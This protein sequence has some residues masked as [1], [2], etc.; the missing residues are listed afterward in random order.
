MA[1]ALLD[2]IA[3]LTA[4][5]LVLVL[6]GAALLAA[7]GAWQ[8]ITPLLRAS[9]AVTA[10][11]LVAAVVLMLTMALH[12]S[13]AHLIWGLGAITIA[14][15][16]V[17]TIRFVRADAPSPERSSRAER[18]RAAAPFVPPSLVLVALGIF[19]A[20]QVRSDTFW[21]VALARRIAELDQLSSAALSFEAGARGNANYPLPVYHA[22]L[23][24]ADAAPRVDLWSATWFVTLWLGP[25]A[26]LAFAGMAGELLGD[27]RAQL[28][29][30][31]TFVAV[32]VLGYGPWY[33]AT[34]YLSYAG[35]VGIL[36]VLPLVV[37]ACTR[38][39]SARGRARA[40]Q[41]AIAAVGTACIGVLHGNYVLYPAL[42][43]GGMAALLLLGRRDAW[44]A[45]LAATGIVVV[46]G[47]VVLGA[48]LPWITNDDNFL[49][50]T[51]DPAGEP[52]A[53]TRHRDVFVGTEQ[54]H[55]VELGSL[56]TQ[57][58]L[59]L[60]ALALPLLLLARRRRAGPW[61]LAGGA[62][63]IVVF[64][65]TPLAIELLDGLGS[66]TPATRFDRVYPAALGVAA[67]AL[68]GGWLL[69][70]SAWER[71]ARTG[72]AASAGAF[73]VVAALAWWLDSI[74]DTRRIVVTAFVEARWV[75]GLDPS[76]IPRIAVVAAT[77]LVLAVAIWIR[78]R[79]RERGVQPARDGAGDQSE[80]RTHRIAAALV[81]AV[82]VGLAPASA[83]RAAKTWQPEAYVRAQR[84]DA[85]YS[86][87]EVYPPAARRAASQLPAGAVVLAGFN[88]AR[89][90]ASLAPVQSVEESILRELVDDPPTRSSAP[91]VLNEL[92]AEW[93]PDYVAA[94][95]Y[96]RSF[97]PLLDAAAA[98]PCRFELVA[99][100]Y[101]RIYRVTGDACS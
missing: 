90:I 91:G 33:F 62:V 50:G 42:F 59:V 93:H 12:G 10:T 77:L 28:V 35:Q 52:T 66:V 88:D 3:T 56:A 84:S 76:G 86:R 37:V 81:I 45:A 48:Q 4:T 2:L 68:A 26:M 43:A 72:R 74:R 22:L 24:V 83:A 53:F 85:T 29:G 13:R 51:S 15:G 18:L 32:V 7:L 17:A 25:V 46:T 27:R 70:R 39:V 89:R 21:H 55:H 9:A 71:S 61:M 6:P 20:P 14:L 36:L 57:P 11:M 38:A 5:A 8:A 23:A 101:L 65:R 80:V 69:Q 97:A 44:R 30:A 64:A 31:W 34:R 19:D 75:G 54:S 82:V 79:V 98:D 78:L 95:R 100:G 67:T 40:V 49:R 63:A 87:I 1:A 47:V 92:I 99:G 73:L 16:I 41:L 60:G 96:D 58:L 94:N